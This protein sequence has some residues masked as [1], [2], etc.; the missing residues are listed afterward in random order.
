VALVD[1]RQLVQRGAKNLAGFADERGPVHAA[2]GVGEGPRYAD[3]DRIR[4]AAEQRIVIVARRGVALYQHF[5]FE[6]VTLHSVAA[7][8]KQVGVAAED[9][10]IAEQNDAAALADAPIQQGD[11]DR[12]EPVFHDVPDA[13][14]RARG[15][16]SKELC[17]SAA[18]SVNASGCPEPSSPGRHP[19][20]HHYSVTG[21]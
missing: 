9:L 21:R 18:G 8:I 17:Q 6:A 10:A 2:A 1:I 20:P 14:R 11:V 7:G 3:A 16:R 12:I 13:G 15:S 19:V 5:A 4:A